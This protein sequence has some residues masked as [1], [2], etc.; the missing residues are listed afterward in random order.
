MRATDKIIDALSQLLEG[1][2]ELHEH[3]EGELGRDEETEESEEAESNPE[4]DAA[5]VT[6]MRGAIEAA[7][8]GADVT[9]EDFG[10]VIAAMTEA[11]EEIDPDIFEGSAGGDDDDMEDLD[12]EDIEE[13]DDLDEEYDDL[14]DYDEDEYDDDD[15]GEEDEEEPEEEDED[16]DDDDDEP[17]RGKGKKKR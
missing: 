10:E 1:F 11:L 5:L 9:A 7:L 3:L 6:E 12:D 16:D 13:I 15:E 4:L 2:K 8:E 14:D 17:R